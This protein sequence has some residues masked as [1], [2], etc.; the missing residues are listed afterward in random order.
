MKPFV[1]WAGGKRQIISRISKFVLE[2]AR[3][4]EDEEFKKHRYIEPF[5]G[6]GAVL[7]EL[8]PHKAI[9]NDLNSD[10][11]NAYTVIAE[12]TVFDLIKRLK[13]FERKYRQEDKD[14]L[15]YSV[16]ELD[17]L[18]NWKDLDP[19]D[20]ASRM[21][22]LNRTCYN[23]LYRV[24]SKG[25]FN[26]PIGR[27]TNPTICDEKN[28]LSIHEY[29]QNNFVIIMNESYEKCISKARAGDVIYVDPPYDYEDDDGFTKYQMNGF[30]FED[31]QKLKACCD[32][33]L[34]RG[35]YVIISNNATERVLNLFRNDATY[36]VYTYDTNKFSTLRTINCKGDNRKNGFEAIFWGIP[37]LV[38]FPQANDINKVIKLAM[39]QEDIY[40]DKTKVADYIG[41]GTDRQAAYYLSAMKFF[42]YI[43][44]LQEPTE[45]LLDLRK[46]GQD[47]LESDMKKKILEDDFVAKMTEKGIRSKEEISIFIQKEYSKKLGPSTA[48][49]RASTIHSWIEW[50]NK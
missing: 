36:K 26:T 14:E 23:G 28:I 50:A 31:F 33:A 8:H 38:P 12:D 13:D 24:N 15:Y 20:K 9:I 7:F 47:A 22:F 19:I 44:N 37:S 34:K 1:K 11:M 3:E 39:S 45:C 41:V 40:S 18:S 27:Y 29:L 21:I 25:Q 46:K 16:R 2:S 43:N 17:R 4:V 6:G 10:L 30:K 49:R 35:A 42:R 48:E 5:L 32:K